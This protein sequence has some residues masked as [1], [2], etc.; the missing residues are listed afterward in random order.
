M[1]S[2]LNQIKQMFEELK[3]VNEKILNKYKNDDTS[4]IKIKYD[5][6]VTRFNDLGNRLFIFLI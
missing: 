5:R 3:N 4:K 6:S 1:K 2:K